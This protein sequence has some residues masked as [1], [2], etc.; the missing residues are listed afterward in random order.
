VGHEIELEIKIY[1]REGLLG[2]VREVI[3]V[4]AE[5]VQIFSSRNLR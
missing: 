5:T 3:I 2:P 4:V 1:G